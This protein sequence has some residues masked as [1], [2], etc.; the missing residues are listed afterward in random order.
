MHLTARTLLLL[1]RLIH[2]TP[3][4]VILYFKDL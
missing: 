4:S 3:V 2:E 1:D